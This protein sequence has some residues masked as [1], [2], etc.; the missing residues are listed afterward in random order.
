ML[1]RLHALAAG[2]HIVSASV[3]LSV[4]LAETDGNL[5][6]YNTR[7]DMSRFL[8]PERWQLRCYNSTS[9]IVLPGPASS[10]P[11]KLEEVFSNNHRGEG[12][13]NIA[14]LA[15]FFAFW[16]GICH[17]R[18][19]AIVDS[20]SWADIERVGQNMAK[21]RWIDYCVSAPLMLLTLNII[22]AA[23][24]SAGVILAPLLLLSLEAAAAIMEYFM[25]NPRPY[26]MLQT[27]M[28]KTWL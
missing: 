22:F 27:L 3:I 5:K 8:K 28:L 12:W 23:T 17:V 1:R 21:W 13:L 7:P 16:S 14:V 10:C 19:V 15:F 18:S 20:A 25:F 2:V 26:W 9:K 4:A 6:R 24:N 11:G